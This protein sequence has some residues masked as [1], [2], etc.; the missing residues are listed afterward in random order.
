MIAKLDERGARPTTLITELDRHNTTGAATDPNNG[1]VYLDNGSSLAAYT[2]NGTLI[3][4]F[5][6]G[7]LTGGLGLAVDARNRRSARARGRPKTTVQVFGLEGT[8]HAPSRT[9]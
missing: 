9:Q 7:Q 3:Q 5:G 2:A 1:N 6:E 4:R 8:P